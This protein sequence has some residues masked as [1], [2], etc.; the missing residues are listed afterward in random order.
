MD[1]FGRTLAAAAV[2]VGAS[3]LGG[4]I[5]QGEYDEQIRNAENFQ[6]LYQDLLGYVDELEAELA[7]ERVETVT[8]TEAAVLIPLADGPDAAELEARK[9]ALE[10]RIAALDGGLGALTAIDVEGGYGFA[11]AENIVFDSGRAELRDEGRELLVSL[12]RQIAGEEFDTIWVRGHSDAMPVRR[13]ETLE[14]FPHGNLQ[15]SAARAVE[16]AAAMIEEGGLPTAKVMVSGFGPTRPIADNG[17]AEGRAQNRRVE[18]F[19]IQ[20]GEDADQRGGL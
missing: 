6:L 15:L 7:R 8:P 1:R 5:T 19:V 3:T 14:R 20:A 9:A 13:A 16:V 10:A 12:A 17:S 11:L 18:I 4:C 2:L